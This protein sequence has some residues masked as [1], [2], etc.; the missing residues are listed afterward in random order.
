MP[1]HCPHMPLTDAPIAP[2]HAAGTAP[3]PRPTGIFRSP[4]CW[5]HCPSLDPREDQASRGAGCTLEPPGLSTAYG[6]SSRK[7]PSLARHSLVSCVH[8]RIPTLVSELSRVN[9]AAMSTYTA[10]D[11]S[12]LSMRARSRWAGYSIT[13]LGVHCVPAPG[14]SSA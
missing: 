11:Q 9:S 6:E 4:H 1:P 5:C 3:A 14:R 12:F 7:R 8:R 10:V 13:I 2:P